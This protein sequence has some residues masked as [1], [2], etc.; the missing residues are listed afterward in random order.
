MLNDMDDQTTPVLYARRRIFTA[1]HA[2]IFANRVVLDGDFELHSH[3]FIEVMVIGAGH[4]VHQ[5]IHGHQPLQTGDIYILRPGVWHAYRACRRLEVSNCCFGLELLQREL[6]WIRDDPLL[7]YLLYS[8]PLG[9]DRR[10]TLAARLSPAALADCLH[11]I[12]ALHRLGVADSPDTKVDLIGHLLLAL[13]QLANHVNPAGA[14]GMRRQK[15]VHDAVVHGMRLLE[16][17]LAYPWSLADLA[18]RLHIDGSYL[19]RLFKTHTGLSAMAYLAHQ[20][21]E[22]AATLALQTDYPIARI[23]QE[24]GWPDPNYFARRF[25]AYFGVSATAYRARYAGEVGIPDDRTH[26]YAE[27]STGE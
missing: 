16:K 21:A 22:R 8:G 3:D 23:G 17:D 6:V 12:D 13:A 26:H 10:G 4:G 14:T 1:A 2:P 5:T 20:R 19:V 18:G 15:P 7:N 25:K 11:H 9:L 24:T 27:V